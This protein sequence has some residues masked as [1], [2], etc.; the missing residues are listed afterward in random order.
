MYFASTLKIGRDHP[1]YGDTTRVGVQRN[2]EHDGY[3][4]GQ[5]AC[6]GYHRIAR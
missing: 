3:G 6:H 5:S 4:Y 1:V 2:V